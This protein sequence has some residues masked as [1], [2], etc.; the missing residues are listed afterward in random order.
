MN[1]FKDFRLTTKII[2]IV[3]LLIISFSGV[4]GLYILPALTSALE[5]SAERKLKNLTETSY[6]I[7][8]FY[9]SQAQKGILTEAQAKEYAKQEIQG[10]RYEETE[11]FW[12]NDYKPSMIM[13]PAKPELNGQDMSDY[14]DPS[15]FKIFVAFTD[16]VKSQGE[17]LV[18]YQWPKPGKD[19]P[20]PKFSYVKGFEPWQWIIGTGIYVDD[21]N[22]VKMAF[23]QKI[24][25][26]VMLVL[27]IALITVTV[28]IIV[29]INKSIKEILSHLDELSQYDFTHSISLDQKD[30]LGL[31]ARAF[32]H[33]VKNI[34]DLVQN[35]R[36]L[37]EMV[38]NESNRM[39]TSTEE[40]SVAS[41]RI[42]IT[43][44][45][46]ARGA[47]EQAKSTEEGSNNIQTIVAGLEHI[48]TD[49]SN[50]AILTNE[51][52]R[53]VKTGAD[54]VGE[55]EAKMIENMKVY[56]NVSATVMNLA[57]K[58]QEISQI[59]EVIKGIAKQTNLL[60]LNAA[61][62][63]AR[64]GEQGRGFAVVAEEVRKLAEQVSV[65]GSQII[66]IVQEVRGGVDH[67]VTDMDIVTR[68]V[69]EQ[70][71]SLTDIVR[72][73]K[74]ISEAVNTT[75]SYINTVAEKT[76]ALSSDAKT[77]AET[78]NK[79]SGIAD[80]TAAGTQEVAALSEEE[81]A[82]IHE[83][84]ERA[85]ELDNVANELQKSIQQFTV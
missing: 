79:I 53:A 16:V 28:L 22:T 68:V 61:I 63:A 3:V 78:L 41:E 7:V 10:L 60:A 30:E 58:S 57:N 52:E 83:I 33:V 85:K 55:Q 39:I 49:M 2:S 31:I 76:K 27:I 51:A 32:N 17:G 4:V 70:E 59:V 24:V 45:E 40:I 46:L 47:V 72:I 43:I 34:R 8:A 13:H 71:H 73:F 50:S 29:P 77:S 5:Q 62:E 67:A 56:Q 18:R 36:Q 44:T 37:S 11:Y 9:Y 64:A 75:G 66:E 81:A 82:T 48:S 15:G 42:A 20:Q 69:K 26:S 1:I 54:L 84:A 23:A 12:I 6:H 35:T 25:I 19:A 21:L 74:S 14:K 65:S 38:V 80:K